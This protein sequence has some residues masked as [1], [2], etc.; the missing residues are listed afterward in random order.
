MF[1]G[2]FL[3]FNLYRDYNFNNIFITLPLGIFIMVVNYITIYSKRETIIEKYNH[4]KGINK[5][6]KLFHKLYL[7]ASIIL[8]LVSFS[9][10][11]TLFEKDV[12]LKN[13][14]KVG[15]IIPKLDPKGDPSKSY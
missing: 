1:L 2:Y 3:D 12:N 11:K 9:L 15:I 10:T 8:Y 5:Y 6:K 4:Q 13:Q 7:L 14:E